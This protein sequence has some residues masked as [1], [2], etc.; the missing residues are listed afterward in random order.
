MVVSTFS[1][2]S[3]NLQ[4]IIYF[5]KHFLIFVFEKQKVESG[6]EKRGDASCSAHELLMKYYVVS[7][8][9]REEGYP[10]KYG[11][12]PRKF[13]RAQPEGTSEGSGHVS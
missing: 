10:M 4:K 6:M 7:V 1:L 8:L 5:L 12:S 3:S 13:P 11:L 9:G 2:N